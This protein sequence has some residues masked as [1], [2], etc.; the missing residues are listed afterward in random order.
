MGG[1]PPARVRIRRRSRCRRETVD[2]APSEAAAEVFERFVVPELAVLAR[3]ARSITGQHADG[4]DLVQDTLLRAFRSIDRFDGRHPRAW[5]LTIMRN[6]HA[7]R[8]RGGPRPVVVADP[9]ALVVERGEPDGSPEAIVVAQVL[10]PSLERAVERLPPPLRQVLDLV[11]LQD[12]ACRDVALALGVGA[13]TVTSRLHRARRRL[14]RTID[15]HAQCSKNVEGTAAP[16]GFQGADRGV[17]PPLDRP[18]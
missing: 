14:R 3:V 6:A 7:N 8:S 11:D 13:G 15:V 1:P 5:L 4:D 9:A 17:A 2:S 16:G 18:S 12:W 10:D